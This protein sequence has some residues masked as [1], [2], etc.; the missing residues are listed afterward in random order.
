LINIDTFE[1]EEVIREVKK[2]Y[3]NSKTQRPK[4]VVFRQDIG[5]RNSQ[6]LLDQTGIDISTENQHDFKSE[7]ELATKV[8]ILCK[9][10]D[11]VKKEVEL[12]PQAA[13]SRQSE[14]AGMEQNKSED[15][16]R[17]DEFKRKIAKC[18][19]WKYF[20][21]KGLLYRIPH[22]TIWKIQFMYIELLSFKPEGSVDIKTEHLRLVRMVQA[23]DKHS[24]DVVSVELTIW[25]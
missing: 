22:T 4:L 15:K 6:E 1:R 24:W 19:L 17:V 23:I 9:S 16:A 13:R 14:V 18:K 7:E 25:T 8:I 11:L 3:S 20:E 5:E 2:A 12:T 21:I 10:K